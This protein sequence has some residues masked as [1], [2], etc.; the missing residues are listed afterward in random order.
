M[1]SEYAGGVVKGGGIVGAVLDLCLS[2]SSRD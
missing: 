2:G 1:L